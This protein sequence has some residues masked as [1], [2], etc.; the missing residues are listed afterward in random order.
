MSKPNFAPLT[1]LHFMRFQGQIL[2]RR[3][4]WASNGYVTDCRRFVL[5]IKGTKEADHSK[6]WVIRHS[7]RVSENFTLPP[8]PKPKSLEL[9]EKLQNGPDWSKILQELGLGGSFMTRSEAL[10]ALYEK[11]GAHDMLEL[12]NY[13]ADLG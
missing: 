13:M 12:G 1:P 11:L 3:P 7:I 5:G 9:K 8:L 6:L 10:T 2:Y 4:A